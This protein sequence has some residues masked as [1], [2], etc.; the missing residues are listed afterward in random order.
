MRVLCGHDADVAEWVAARIPHVESDG[1]GKC[2]GVG[3]VGQTGSLMAGV[4]FH[5]YQPACG[6]VQLSC[7]ADTPK[8]A[9]RKIVRAI[10]HV[11]FMQYACNKVWTATPHQN[12]RAIK[13]N[14]G[15]GFRPE[16]T[17]RHQFGPKQHA[18]ICSMLRSEYLREYGS[19]D[20]APGAAFADGFNGRPINAEFAR[21]AAVGSARV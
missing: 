2:V 17:L 21:E 11:P 14:K 7:A 1:F 19:D 4:V 16:A 18:V 5:D 10:L 13:F 6:T 20:V 9:S 15:I 8:W 3:V 12:E